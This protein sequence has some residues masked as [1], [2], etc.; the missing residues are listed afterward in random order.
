MGNPANPADGQKIIFQVTQGVRRPVH[1]RLGQ[2]LRVL[3]RPAAAHAQH[4]GRADRPARL[5]LQRG[6]GQVAA[7]RV[8][9]GFSTDDRH[10]PKG[11]YRLFPTTSGPS[12]PVSYTGPFIAGVVFE[13]TTG[14][15]WLDGYWWWVCPSGQ[16][17]AAQKFALWAV[18]NGADRGTG[19]RATVTSGAADRR[20]VELRAAAHADT[21]GHRRQLHRLRPGSTA[22]SRTPTTSSAAVTRTVPGS[23][24]ARCPHSRTGP[25]RWPSLSACLRACSASRA[26]IP[27][28]Q[29]AGRRVQLAPTSG[30]TS[31]STPLRRG[32]VLPAVAELP[33]DAGR[34]FHSDTPATRWRRSSSCRSPARW[35]TSGIYSARCGRAADQ[36]RDL[37]RRHADAWSPAPTTPRRPGRARPGPAG[38][39]A[40]TAASRFPPG[41]TRWRCSTAAGRSGTRPPPTT[42]ASGGPG[43]N[44]ITAGPVTA[45]GL[46]A[47]T[48]PGQ[49]TYN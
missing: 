32:H 23:S 24:T 35:T 13:V 28:R 16:S 12:S 39:P 8:R 18:Y 47:A 31:R 42:G 43:G 44:G 22:A 11:T 38:S 30:W 20:A 1:P 37:E 34:R 7:G 2:R 41:T 15:C 10:P 45:P 21:A 6:Q 4:D 14:G 46:S 25:G 19:R 26:P 3:H 36:V 17:T 5:H 9:G 29:H 48:S 33:D 49:S 27:R 40:R